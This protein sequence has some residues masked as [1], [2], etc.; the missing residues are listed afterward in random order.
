MQRLFLTV[1]TLALSSA[2]LGT[3]CADGLNAPINPE[4]FRAWSNSRPEEQALAEL[5]SFLEG[6]T[7]PARVIEWFET[8]GFHRDVTT[9][10]KLSDTGVEILGYPK[11]DYY[12]LGMGWNDEK[13]GLIFSY[14]ILP[15]LDGWFVV[16]GFGVWIEYRH[17][18]A[19]AETPIDIM[20]IQISKSRL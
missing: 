16:Y 10:R 17:D 19:D 5:S 2:L 20:T 1:C 3:A 4:K 14:G 6:L 11:G 9:P 13:N 18:A 8:A 12:S 15:R 7:G